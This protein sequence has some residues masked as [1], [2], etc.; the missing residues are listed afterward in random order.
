MFYMENMSYARAV[1]YVKLQEHLLDPANH[2]EKIQSEVSG[3]RSR[4]GGEERVIQI[5][6]VSCCRRN[7]FASPVSLALI[8][9][10]FFFLLVFPY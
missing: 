1:G 10:E 7:Q 4:G 2:N 6:S 9:E 8:C 5:F 3:A